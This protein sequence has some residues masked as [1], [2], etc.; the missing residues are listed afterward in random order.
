MLVYDTANKL[1]KEI[2]DSSEYKEYKQLKEKVMADEQTKSLLGD[3][4]KL[5]FEAQ[6]AYIAGNEPKPESVEKLKKLGE[7]LA[8]NKEVT[9]FFAAEYKF[10]TLVS[11]IYNIIGEACDLGL[12]FLKE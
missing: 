10:Q 11:D 8:F 9:E 12:D 1:A 3:Y 6:A 7:V 2:Q 4:K 5:Q